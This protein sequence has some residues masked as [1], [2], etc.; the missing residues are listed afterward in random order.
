M[1]IVNPG[2]DLNFQQ[3]NIWTIVDQMEKWTIIAIRNGLIRTNFWPILDKKLE[4]TVCLVFFFWP[5][6][7]MVLEQ[8]NLL[9]HLI[10]T[11]GKL[12][13]IYSA[14]LT[15]VSII[16][17]LSIGLTQFFIH[18]TIHQFVLINEWQIMLPTHWK[19]QTNSEVDFRCTRVLRAPG[20]GFMRAQRWRSCVRER[21]HQ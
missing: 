11:G 7:K 19:K 17:R 6:P 18:R 3:E 4:Y 8:Q 1:Q 16:R 2:K 10:R 12:Q 21:C 15:N 5:N 20:F 14:M 13:T 9:L